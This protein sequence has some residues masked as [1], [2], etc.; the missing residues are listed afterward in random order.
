MV[1]AVGTILV[2][3]AIVQ[4]YPMADRMVLFT[5]P[6]VCLLLGATLMI[7]RQIY[8]QLALIVLVFIVG[9]NQIGS[10]ASAVIHPYTKTEVREAYLFALHHKRPSDAVLVEWEGVPDYLYYHQTLGVSAVGTFSLEG[11]A[12]PCNNARQFAKLKKWKRVW[13]VFG[14]DPG[15]EPGHPIAQYVS[16]FDTFGQSATAYYSP[17]PA[18]AVLVSISHGPTHPGPLLR[19]QLAAQSLWMYFNKSLAP[20]KCSQIDRPQLKLSIIGCRR[21]QSVFD[22]P[23]TNNL[24][25]NFWTEVLN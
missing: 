14:I 22:H 10:A 23:V 16:A 13:L 21:S 4:D 5:V 15:T 1:L 6:F 17:G 9:T 12:S 3:A 2:I 25:T 7:S 20:C 24:A 18:G 19:P 11:S 8:V